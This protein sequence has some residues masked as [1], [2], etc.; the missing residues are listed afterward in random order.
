MPTGYT[1]DIKD[2]I[3]FKTFAMNC[4]RAFGACVTIRDEPSGGDNIPDAFEPS[5]Y[6]Q[7]AVEKAR[8][9]LTALDAM[10]AEDLER[11]AVSAWDEAETRRAVRL[12]EMRQQR[13]SYEAMLA[14][15][16][17]W[18]PPTQDHAGLQQFMREQIERSIDFDCDESYYRDPTAR[19][20]GAKWRAARHDELA[21]DVQYHER[22]Y[23]EEMQRTKDRTEWVRAL[24]GSLPGGMSA[25]PKTGGES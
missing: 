7:L 17:A 25:S 11:A 14:R 8:A 3:D 19:M 23:A 6:H 10:T 16:N 1:A 13:T 4:A 22:K 24:R 9:D 20:T 2:G 12:S 15:V 18:T 21:R 5:D